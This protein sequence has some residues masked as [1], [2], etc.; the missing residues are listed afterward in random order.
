MMHNNAMPCHVRNAIPCMVLRCGAVW[1]STTPHSTHLVAPGQ[2]NIP[3]A[4][5]EPGLVDSCVETVDTHHAVD[6][7]SHPVDNH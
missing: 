7:Q 5:L 1:S 2:D 3:L 6:G 4:N